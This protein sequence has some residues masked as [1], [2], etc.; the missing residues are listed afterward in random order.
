MNGRTLRNYLFLTL[1]IAIL[2]VG[3]WTI[4]QPAASPVMEAWT[5]AHEFFTDN[6]SFFYLGLLAAIIL[7]GHL[8]RL[9]SRNSD[10]DT[11]RRPLDAGV[12]IGARTS[13]SQ[14]PT[15]LEHRL[16]D[17]KI[18][19]TGRS[20]EYNQAN[21]GDTANSFSTISTDTRR[22][23]TFGW[24]A[25]PHIDDGSEATIDA[26]DD[27]RTLAISAVTTAEAEMDH[28]NATDAIDAGNW[29]DDRVAAAFL[30]ADH[31]DAPQF[32]LS[33]RVTAWLF[34]SRTFDRRVARTLDAVDEQCGVFLTH[35]SQNT[36]TD[37]T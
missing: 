13:A 36:E 4:I 20:W 8:V 5:T 3:T 35:S 32:T 15:L 23:I 25:R 22:L 2:A 19:M 16:D 27:L 12:H 31:D 14:P 28:D 10:S 17:A 30:A 26:L 34:P 33:E 6:S 11:S 9:S 21:P 29:T 1:G 18:D 37:S 7:G 24:K